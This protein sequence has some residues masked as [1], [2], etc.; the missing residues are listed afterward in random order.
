MIMD[1]RRIVLSIM[2][3]SILIFNSS[4]AV[5]QEE[6]GEGPKFVQDRF[7][8]SF[9]FDPPADDEMD[10]RYKEIA[11]AHFNLV[12]GGFGANT[13]VTVNKQLDLCEKY[14]MDAI[15][16]LPGYV[17]GAKDGLKAYDDIKNHQDFPDHKACLGY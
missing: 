7:V 2:V 14:G 4:F 8:I 17:K 6:K 3:A 9:W 1:N 10:V 12:L 11:E 16:S 13:E 15:V 5:A